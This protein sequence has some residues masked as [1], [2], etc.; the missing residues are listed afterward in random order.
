MEPVDPEVADE[1][2]ALLE[3]SGGAITSTRR[4]AAP[5]AALSRARGVTHA[6]VRRSPARTG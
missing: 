2:R 1:L 5:A 3:R 6:M 4:S